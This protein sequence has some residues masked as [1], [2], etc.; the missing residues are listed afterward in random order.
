MKTWKIWTGAAVLMVLFTLAGTAMMAGTGDYTYWWASGDSPF[1][2]YAQLVVDIEWENMDGKERPPA[3]IDI[4]R[5]VEIE[6][7][8]GDPPPT[9]PEESAFAHF[10]A[11]SCGEQYY[12]S[13]IRT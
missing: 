5:A 2:P 12:Y 9:L 6:H 11:A 3:R 4:Y 10:D 7:T 13:R 1:L 8:Y